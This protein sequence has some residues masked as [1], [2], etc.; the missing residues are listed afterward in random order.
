MK[1]F[2]IRRVLLILLTV[3]LFLS[4]GS[5]MAMASVSEPAGQTE[6]EYQ[7]ALEII[8]AYD[9][10]TN[11][12]EAYEEALAVKRAYEISAYST[13]WALLPP[14]VAIVLA[15]I[16]KEVYVSLFLGIVT[17]ALLYANGNPGRAFTAIFNEAMIPKISGGNVGILIFLVVLGILVV[18]MNKAGGSAAYGQWAA[19]KIKSKKGAQ[20]ATLGLGALIFVDDYFNC[21]TV[22]SVM[23]PV[24]DKYGV[25]R[26]KLAYII[27]ATAA[28]VCI[29]APISSWAAA[30]AGVV[31]GD[32]S[33]LDLFIRSIPYNF[34]ALLTLIMIIVITA[35]NF[36]YGPMRLHEENAEKGDLYTTADR[37]YEGQQEIKVSS[38]GKVID[39]VLPVVILIISCVIGM[40]YTG[41][42]FSGESFVSA[43]ANCDASRGLVYG[44]V[45]ALLL[46][47][48]IYVP[49]R[50]LT[51][52]EFA[53]SFVDGFRSMVPAI[54]ILVF[55]WTLSGMTKELLGADRFVAGIVSQ[56]AA[57]LQIFLPAIVFVIALGLAF[58]TGTSW[59]TFGILL[60]IVV[61]VLPAGSEMMVIAVSACLAGAVCG[62]HI[63]PI[64]DTT[65][66]ASTGAQSD[67]LN[68]V[69]T[70]IPYAMTVA[71]VSF[72]AYIIAGLV[73]NV[74]IALPAA[75]LLL[76]GVLLL[77][78]SLTRRRTSLK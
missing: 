21:L 15:L 6:A 58:S 14:V 31:E 51:F 77:I 45:A 19:S 54:M 61:A 68:H 72:V 42:F 64:S 22:G 5:F 13:V 52:K 4:T 34:Y 26:A 43:F 75:I 59:G 56:S 28:P 62:D 63:S 38:R 2:R 1:I 60:P 40:I 8:A 65:I 35:M 76:L 55:A 70:Q 10:F 27:D 18:L 71:A 50:V 33:G 57:G 73:Q 11:D 30:V 74:F 9:S 37:P 29:I 47:F 25:S 20:F 67:H 49:R 7:E 69:S 66:M 41:G 39:L 53:S 48:F 78:R 12:T 23:R 24:T 16:T 3:F 44:S 17:G 32:A 36:D 46:T